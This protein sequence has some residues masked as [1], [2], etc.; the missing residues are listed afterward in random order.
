MN[1]INVAC[2]II[3]VLIFIACVT[4]VC[5]VLVSANKRERWFWC[6]VCWR[7]WSSMG[8]I[9]EI[10]FEEDYDFKPCPVCAANLAQKEQHAHQHP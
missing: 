5:A 6:R 10:P 9:N 1:H 7:F 8:R 3:G 4:L 2:L